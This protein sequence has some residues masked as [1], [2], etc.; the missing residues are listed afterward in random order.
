VKLDTDAI[1]TAPGFSS[2]LADA[3]AGAPNAGIAG[4]YRIRA[5]GQA[6]D[7]LYHRAV[8]ERERVSDER[9]DAAVRRAEERGWR[10]GDAVQGGVLTLTRAACESLRDDGW[11]EWRPAW[12]SQLAEDFL[13]T[14][15]TIAGGRDALSL[16]GPDGILAIANKFLP[17]P[18][19]EIIDGPWVAAHS[20]NHGFHGES[21][22]QLRER[23]REARRWWYASTRAPSAGDG[24]GAR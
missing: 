24:V 5:D 21:Q 15:F 13:L 18:T 14:L 19:D 3:L 12:H 22:E 16:G 17:L 11:L 2:A 9:L 10:S 7:H 23:F 6:E 20:V 1:V 4:S 8:L